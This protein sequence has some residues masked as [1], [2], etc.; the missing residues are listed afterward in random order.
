MT[1]ARLLDGAVEVA[2]ARLGYDCHE[3]KLS[4]SFDGTTPGRG[5]VNPAPVEAGSLDPLI[6]AADLNRT[7]PGSLL[8]RVASYARSRCSP[9]QAGRLQRAVRQDGWRHAAVGPAAP[10]LVIRLPA[11]RVAEFGIDSCRSSSDSWQHLAKAGRGEAHTE[12]QPISKKGS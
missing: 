7:R 10:E 4:S 3:I 9:H 8:R 6:P 1:S 5:G 12:Y 2:A 11:R